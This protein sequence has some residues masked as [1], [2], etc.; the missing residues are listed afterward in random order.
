LVGW[1][2]KTNWRNGKL[3]LFGEAVDQHGQHWSCRRESGTLCTLIP[4]RRPAWYGAHI[5]A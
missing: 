3:G 2:E 1:T 4:T 5:W